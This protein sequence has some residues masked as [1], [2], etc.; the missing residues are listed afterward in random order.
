MEI[1]SILEQRES[2]LLSQQDINNL[3]N[4]FDDAYISLNVFGQFNLKLSP[5]D[6]DNSNQ[7]KSRSEKVILFGCKLI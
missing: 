3:V 5:G 7:A 2:E 6:L 1:P 4:A